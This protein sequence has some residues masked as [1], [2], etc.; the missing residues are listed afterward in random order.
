MRLL[1]VEDDRHLASAVQIGMRQHGFVID[2]IAR[3]GEFDGA[4]QGAAYDCVLLD[5]GLPDIG[6][7]ALLARIRAAR[8]GRP[9]IVITARSKV[10]DRVDLLNL[11]ADDYL[12]KPFDLAELAAR[13][14][15]LVRRSD[16]RHAPE[17]ELVCG[18]IKLSVSS[19]TVTLHGK[20]VPLAKKEFW[21]LETFMRKKNQL[22]PREMLEQALYGW[23]DAV[24]SNAVEVY[25]HH[26]R[27]KFGVD[28]I[29]TVRGEGYL[30]PADA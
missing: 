18:G 3:G 11:G 25:V 12:V 10:S 19:R 29:R 24:E 16:A 27:R 23:G 6:G 15:A 9:I 2:W 1:L 22:I 30:L 7:E 28:V 5:L 14:H 17:V 26:L 20:I 13:V 8:D 21:L 4:L